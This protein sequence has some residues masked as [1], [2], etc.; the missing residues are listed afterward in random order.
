MNF[1]RSVINQ[2]TATGVGGGT[3][4]TGPILNVDGSS[5]APQS[6]ERQ[7]IALGNTG[8]IPPITN[9]IFSSDALGSTRYEQRVH[10]RIAPAAVRSGLGR[11]GQQRSPIPKIRITIWQLIDRET[12]G[13]S[14]APLKFALLHLCKTNQRFI[15][16]FL[17]H[18]LRCYSLPVVHRRILTPTL[19]VTPLPHLCPHQRNPHQRNPHPRNPHQR[20]RPR[21]QRRVLAVMLQLSLQHLIRLQTKLKDLSVKTVMPALIMRWV[22]KALRERSFCHQMMTCGAK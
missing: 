15:P 6:S 1:S 11:L 22:Q 3:R 13:C 12:H 9:N 2:N 7:R 17:P 14:K 8:E 4:L 21:P 10:L 20:N 18:Q 16:I 5:N 19:P